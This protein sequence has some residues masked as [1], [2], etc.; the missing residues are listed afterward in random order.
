MLKIHVSDTYE[1][2]SRA[3]AECVIEAVAAKPAASIVLPTGN[4]PLGLYAELVAGYRRGEFDPARLRIFQ[5]DAYLGVAPDDPRSVYSRLERDVLIPLDIAPARVVRL[6]GDTDDPGAACRAYDDAVAASGGYD[7]SVLGIGPNGHLGFNDPPADPTSST[8]VV[9]LA[10]ASIV[11]AAAKLG[12]RDRVPR[13]ALTAGMAPLLAA[14]QTLLL[15][16]GES[17][18]DILQRSLQGPISPDVPASFLQRS[19]N[20]TV[21]ADRAAWPFDQ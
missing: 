19:S 18:R 16:S 9:E 8:R 13:R 15:V 7:I 12:G 5:L 14:G 21:F 10:E 20:V 4:S 3:A 17:K 6:P 11:A 1:T 2:M